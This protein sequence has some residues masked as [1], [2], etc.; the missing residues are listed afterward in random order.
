MAYNP[1]DTDNL[2]A[3]EPLVEAEVLAFYEN[4]IAIARGEDGAP[5]LY[6]RALEQLEAGDEIRSRRDDGVSASDGATET[7]L[8]F[9]FMQ[10][11][12][13]RASFTAA[14]MTGATCSV[15]RRRNG[16]DATLA[17]R[18]TNGTTTVDIPVLSGDSVIFQVT[19]GA[20]GSGAI[21]NCRLSTNGQDL[22]AGVEA[23]VEGNR[24]AT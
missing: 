1:L 5:R 7:S 18:T 14:S 3:G 4:P 2:L 24:A 17:S 13:I 22:W 11:G 9:G 8:Q 15:I 19:A 20:L 12:T 16:S 10:N 23:R 21:T 6:L